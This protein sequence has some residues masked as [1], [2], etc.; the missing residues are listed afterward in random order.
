M[1][2]G[3][4]REVDAD[5]LVTFELDGSNGSFA[6]DVEVGSL[7]VGGK[8][9]SSSIASLSLVWTCTNDRAKCVEDADVV[10]GPTGS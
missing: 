4:V 3:L 6:Q 10:A 2:V 9:A 1:K 8:V 5:R 7:S